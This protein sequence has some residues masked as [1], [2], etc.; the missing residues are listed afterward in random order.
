M[1]GSS[2]GAQALKLVR[3]RRALPAPDGAASSPRFAR[4]TSS[5]YLLH[6]SFHV[7]ICSHRR[8]RKSLFEQKGSSGIA[9][10]EKSEPVSV[11]LLLPLHLFS[12]YQILLSFGKMNGRPLNPAGA[13][14][15]EPSLV[16]GVRENPLPAQQQRQS[17][18]DVENG[19]GLYC[20]LFICISESC[21]LTDWI[22][23]SPAPARHLNSVTSTSKNSGAPYRA[24]LDE[25]V[26]TSFHTPENDQFVETLA[27][28]ACRVPFADRIL[29]HGRR[30][31]SPD[32]PRSYI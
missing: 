10:R 11:R 15:R 6:T 29:R 13:S 5:G 3:R 7:S 31:T 21:G 20:E 17:E 27:V 28:Q 25:D 30:P 19:L 26:N 2:A 1:R 22:L 12:K 18:K 8:A 23:G 16:S 14:R 32:Y 24:F 4:T 9:A